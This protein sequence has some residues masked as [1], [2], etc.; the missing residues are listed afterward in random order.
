MR[1]NKLR[2]EKGNNKAGTVAVKKSGVPIKRGKKQDDDESLSDSGSETG[3]NSDEDQ[4]F[5]GKGDDYIQKWRAVQ[6]I[7]NLKRTGAFLSGIQ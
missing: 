5:F 6:R 4:I 1:I 3:W 2:K 7:V